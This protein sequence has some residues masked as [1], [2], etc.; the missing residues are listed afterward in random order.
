M[1]SNLQTESVEL[2][3]Q[4]GLKEYEAK[5]Y[6]ALTRL[7]KGTA[8]EIS[9]VTDV[10]RT[11]VYDAIRVLEAKGLVDVQHSSPRQYRAASVEEAA[12]LLTREYESRVSSLTD[13]LEDLPDASTDSES[14]PVGEIWSLNNHEAINTRSM[15]LAEEATSEI[16]LVVGDETAI[17][18]EFYDALSDAVDRGVRVII[19]TVNEATR[20]AILDRIS[21]ADV[22]VSDLSWVPVKSNPG[23]TLIT[24][25]L[26]V[27]KQTIVVGSRPAEGKSEEAEQAV[28]GNGT[29]NGIVVILRHLLRTGLLEGRPAGDASD[30]GSD[31]ETD[32]PAT[33]ERS[34]DVRDGD[35]EP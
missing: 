23:G 17:T 19:G 34:R 35:T 16:I 6:V 10:P 7:P 9:E 12:S 29:S 4:L 14:P 11:R 27:D 26:L 15:R 24:R 5:C 33:G 32:N 8:K 18:G 20:T 13:K 22:F 3:Q 28:V 1:S 31:G 21:G 30:D 25:L 2:L